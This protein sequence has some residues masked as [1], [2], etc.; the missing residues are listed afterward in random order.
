MALIFFRFS[1]ITV[2]VTPRP[3]NSVSIFNNSYLWSGNFKFAFLSF[4]KTL[5]NEFFQ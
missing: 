3:R 5:L 1:F 4:L 2:M